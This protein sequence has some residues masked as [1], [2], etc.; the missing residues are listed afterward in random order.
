[1][2]NA[3]AQPSP[4]AADDGAARTRLRHEIAAAS[5][6]TVEAL[7]EGTPTEPIA[8]LAAASHLSETAERA[9]HAIVADA[10]E[11]GMTWAGIGEALGISRQAAQ[12]RFSAQVPR[13]VAA[14]ASAPSEENL[15]LARA[16]MADAAAG[17]FQRFD[18][19]AS[20]SLRRSMSGLTW[21][22]AFSQ[23][24]ELFGEVLERGPVQAQSV[25]RTVRVSAREERRVR[26]VTVEVLL[27]EGGTLLGMHY[28]PIT[29]PE[30]AAAPTE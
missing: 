13:R 28:T 21:V 23:V 22:D 1:M 18:Q 7:E 15:E 10:R 8:A 12:K 30:G 9:L 4:H 24:G 26:P 17:D 20:T 2:S 3:S 29:P 25:G 5:A 19:I 16:L 6:V 27:T 11:A 14:P